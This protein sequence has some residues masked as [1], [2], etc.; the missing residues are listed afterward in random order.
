V[1][2]FAEVEKGLTREITTSI[3]PGVLKTKPNQA[4]NTAFE[5]RRSG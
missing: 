5:F 1:T 3:L 2:A 4:G